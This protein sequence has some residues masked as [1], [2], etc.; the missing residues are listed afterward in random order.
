MYLR[1]GLRSR[2]SRRRQPFAGGE[3]RVA[4]ETALETAQRV[5]W[6]LA[7]PSSIDAGAENVAGVNGTLIAY[8]VIKRFLPQV[9]VA[10]KIRLEAF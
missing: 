1:E 5:S 8:P 4:T 2:V 7:A 9:C 3:D 10:F 6:L